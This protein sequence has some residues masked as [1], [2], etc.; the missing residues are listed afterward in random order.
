MCSPHQRPMCA[1]M[2]RK[3]NTVLLN[4]GALE[5]GGRQSLEIPRDY[6][7]SLHPSM[8]FK[9]Q[10]KSEFLALDV[11][12]YSNTPELP[13]NTTWIRNNPALSASPIRRQSE[14]IFMLNTADLFVMVLQVF[15]SLF[16]NNSLED[17]TQD[18]AVN[19]GAANNSLLFD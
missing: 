18:R 16:L 19:Q 3:H 5:V 14:A 8:E 9:N 6:I 17:P 7:F 13:G 11:H 4:K 12:I 10:V 1:L 15:V 2:L